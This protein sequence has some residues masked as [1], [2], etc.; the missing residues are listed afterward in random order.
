MPIIKHE[1]VST[2]QG[3]SPGLEVQDLVDAAHG[4]A[5]LKVGV[6]TVPPNSRIPRHIHANTEQAMVVLEGRLD[7]VL[8]R[9][10]DTVEPGQTVLAPSGTTHG[11]TNPYPEPAKL[12]FVFP[13]HDGE[14][15]LASIDGA[16][17]GF[18]SEAGLTGY[19]SPTE[20]PLDQRD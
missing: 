16:T 5:S 3:S 7:V 13:T 4:S 9:Q 2:R 15:V 19:S 10:R 6:I 11:F 17:S 1:D 12:L 18:R 20:R 8:G 14:R